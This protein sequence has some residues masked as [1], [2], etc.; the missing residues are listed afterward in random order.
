ML[1]SRTEDKFAEKYFSLLLSYAV[2]KSVKSQKYNE[3]QCPF[4][5]FDLK[6]HCLSLQLRKLASTISG[7]VSL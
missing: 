1:Q 5:H 6:I 7:S 3:Q 2:T 4:V